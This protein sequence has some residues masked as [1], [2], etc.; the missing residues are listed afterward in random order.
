M[1]RSLNEEVE[2]MLKAKGI[3]PSDSPYASP[4]VLVKK[5][6]GIKQF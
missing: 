1:K 3:E 6:D 5:K 2:K 4:F